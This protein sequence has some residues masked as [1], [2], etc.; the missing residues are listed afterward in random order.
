MSEFT[1]KTLQADT[2]EL[3]GDPAGLTQGQ[4][5]TVTEIEPPGQ[6]EVDRIDANTS[7]PE[8]SKIK[9]KAHPGGKT[10][11]FEVTIE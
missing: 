8:K 9:L 7:A 10:G 3:T 2:L 11:P 6:Y 4:V 1:A 5:V